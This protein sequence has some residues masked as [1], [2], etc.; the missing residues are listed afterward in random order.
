M[1]EH[2]VDCQGRLAVDVYQDGETWL[3]GCPTIDVLTQADTEEEALEALQ[4]AVDGWFE[5]ATERGTLDAALHEVFCS[6]V[7]VLNRS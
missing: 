2:F 6:R 1:S 5:S 3:A 7:Y 4:E